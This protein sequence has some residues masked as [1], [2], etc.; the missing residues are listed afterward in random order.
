MHDM[1][2]LNPPPSS[3]HGAITSSI[4]VA[5]PR[6]KVIDVS[7]APSFAWRLGMCS[8]CDVPVKVQIHIRHVY[9]IKFGRAEK[10]AFWNGIL[11]VVDSG[12]F[13]QLRVIEARDA[14]L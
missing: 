7:L 1:L 6:V 10:H 8:R 11:V 14:R 5:N 13:A 9:I 4:H 2:D 3:L 12:A